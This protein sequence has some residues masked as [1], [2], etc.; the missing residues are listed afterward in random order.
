MASLLLSPSYMTVTEL[1]GMALDYDLTSY[2][3]TQLT[4]ALN[5]AS[6]A[7]NSI[8]RQNLLAQEVT[9]TFF[10][11]G[12]NILALGYRPLLYVKQMQ[13]VQP[14]IVGYNIPVNRV[15]I[16]YVKG[17]I[18]QYSPLELQGVGFVS[19]FPNGLPIAITYAF[20]YGYNPA[21]SPTWT[22]TDAQGGNGLAPGTYTVGITTKT[23][24]GE[25]LPSFQNVTT[26]TGV[27]SVTIVP[28]LGAW[29]YRYFIA[30]GTNQ[31]ANAKLVGEIPSTNFGGESTQATI[32]SLTPPSGTYVESAPTTDTSALP[33][34][35]EFRQ[36]VA[37]LVLSMI[38]E[39]NNLANRGIARTQS[40]RKGVQWR[41]TTG[42]GGRGVP[43]LWEQAEEI[44][45]PRKLSTIF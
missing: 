6:G 31:Q 25:T 19:V 36:A 27:I 30:A 26:T 28:V 13:F 34:P 39:Q 17:E 45:K 4:D 5:R 37:L 2:S 10:G 7:A 22:A 23:M 15:L 43:T 33:T 14:G 41:P 40:A 44:L 9:K 20:G 32:S 29:K 12:S 24:W 35:Q 21:V 8:M 38:Y 18:V 1:R 3:D 11:E 42:T 16:D